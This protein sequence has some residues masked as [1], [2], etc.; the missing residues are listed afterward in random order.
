MRLKYKIL[1]IT[2]LMI[3]NHQFIYAQV[4]LKKVGQSTM[5]FLLVNVSVRAAALGETFIAVGQGA[6]SIFFNPAGL[7]EIQ[8]KYE[9]KVS[10]TQW[11]ADINYMAGAFAWKAGSAG[12]F[13]LSLL[14]VDYG[15][16][17]G[18]SL[19]SSADLIL[20]P[21]GYRDD[22]ALNNVGAYAIGLSYGKS[23]TDQFLAGGNIRF[24]AQN[25]GQ[26]TM[27]GGLV[28]ENNANKMIFDAGVKYYTGLKS[29]RFGMAIRNFSSN[30]KREEI[31]E[32]LPLLFTM[33]VALNV[34]DVILS[35]PS[36]E[37]SLLFA[38]DFLHPNNYTERLNLGLEY[39]FWNM[40]SLRCGFQTNHDTASWSA[41]IGVQTKVGKNNVCFDY[42]YSDLD[43][44]QYVNRFS[45]GVNF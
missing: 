17:Y 45:L 15:T 36:D 21:H 23:I 19:I 27:E 31:S 14:W 13:G 12:T 32:P 42:S 2:I 41:G 10:I 3:L 11:I 18:T 5:N 1:L 38:V 16:I 37:N 6:E 25:L 35:N 34:F 4:G 8:S 40:L 33:G 7:S 28:E 24:A 29:F 20:Y 44:F 26:N 22:G 43:I 39:N 30:L 9:L